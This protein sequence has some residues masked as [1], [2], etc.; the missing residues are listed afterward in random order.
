MIDNTDKYL[1]RVD[2]DGVIG[3]ECPL[4]SDEVMNVA[5]NSGSSIRGVDLVR[6]EIDLTRYHVTAGVSESPNHRAEVGPREV[7]AHCVEGAKEAFRKKLE[8]SDRFSVRDIKYTE[9]AR[10]DKNRGWVNEL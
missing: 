7:F 4:D 6:Q 5:V 10:Y 8:S 2:H 3:T 9:V 1:V